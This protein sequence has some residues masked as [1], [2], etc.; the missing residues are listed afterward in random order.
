MPTPDRTSLTEIVD[1]GRGILESG[2]PARLTMQAVAERVGVRAPSLYKRVRD[3]DALLTLVVEATANDL[4]HRLEESDPTIAGLARTYRS[5]AHRRPEGFRLLFTVEGADAAMSRAAVPVLRAAGDL[6]GP[7]AALDAARLLT[8]WAT[9]FVNME[10][11]GSFRL[12]GDVEEA[13]EY[14]LDRL[15]VALRAP[16]ATAPPAP[17]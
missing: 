5:F 2:G 7:D 4:A 11:S 8:A 9:G 6:V 10:L 1:A 12:G 3:R 17:K 14:G 15:A 13:F 16:L